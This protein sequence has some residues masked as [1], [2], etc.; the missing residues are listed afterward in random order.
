MLVVV[1]QEEQQQQRTCVS[2]VSA[3]F[4][5]NRCIHRGQNVHVCQGNVPKTEPRSLMPPHLS[6]CVQMQTF[7]PV[8]SQVAAT[9]PHVRAHQISDRPSVCLLLRCWHLQSNVPLTPLFYI[10]LAL[11]PVGRLVC[12]GQRPSTACWFLCPP[13]MH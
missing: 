3:L 1:S 9:A 12:T 7:F 11:S 6:S 13:K 8:G 10:L 5:L 2:S 4:L